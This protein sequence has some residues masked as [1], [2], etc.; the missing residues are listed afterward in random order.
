MLFLA[1][2]APG[3][4]DIFMNEVE[5]SFSCS[6]KGHSRGR[7]LFEC[8]WSEGLSW[9]FRELR[10]PHAIYIVLLREVIDKD[11]RGLQQIREYVSSLSWKMFFSPGVSFGVRAERVGTGHSYTSMDI[12]SISGESIVETLAEY[13]SLVTVNLNS[14]SLSIATEVI[15]NVLYVLLRLYGED[16]LHRRWYRIYEHPA[17]LKPSIAYAM[18]VISGLREGEVLIDPVC[19]GGTIPIEAAL[20]YENIGI[21]CN[22]VSSRSIRMARANAKM[23]R[24][25]SR[26]RFYNFEVSELSRREIGSVDRIVC[27]P[28]FGIRMGNPQKAK[29][30]TEKIIE[31][32]TDLLSKRGSLTLITP[33]RSFVKDKAREN[34]FDIVEERSVLHGSLEAWILSFSV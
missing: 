19:G 21:I 8:D 28:P 11:N 34:G 5:K 26:I 12:A 30:V 16:S 24:V 22:D 1:K 6:H 18:L 27:N 29:H 3:L 7:I 33:Y 2:T 17:S 31:V 25:D 20:Y 14:P 23:A 15:D 4:E 13:G 10:T 9:G 32:S